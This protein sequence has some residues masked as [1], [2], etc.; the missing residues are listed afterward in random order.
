MINKTKQAGFTLV[1]LAIV[2]VII[3]LIVGGVLVG[4]DLIKAA[5]I[6]ATVTDIEKFNAA[7]TTFRG[8][9][10]GYPG[11]LIGPKASEFGF[12]VGAARS[13]TAPAAG[14]GDGNSLIEGGSPTTPM[15]IG[16]ETALFWTDLSK[17]GL[18]PAR[19]TLTGTTAIAQTASNAALGAGVLPRSKLRDNA[20]FTVFSS[21]GRNYYGLGAFSANAGAITNAPGLSPLEAR[22]IDEKLDDGVPLS[23]TVQAIQDFTTDP[24]APTAATLNTPGSAGCVVGVAP[25]NNYNSSTDALLNAIACSITVRASF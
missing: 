5:T 6:R 2:L 13:A 25:Q 11:D 4:Q 8:K 21:T 7:A 14:Q 1:E 9:F 10:G 16:F 17:A 19:S 15:Y 24:L 23:G 12:E 18:I 3:G 20:L 22:G